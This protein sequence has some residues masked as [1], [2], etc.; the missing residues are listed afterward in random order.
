MKNAIF[1]SIDDAVRAI[2][3]L[4]KPE[5]ILFIET[6]A[7]QIATCFRS[8]G[9]ILIAGNGGSLCDAMHFAEELTGQ[10]RHKRMALPALALADPGHLSCVSN[11]MGY[12][13]VFARGVEAFGKKED[14]F[15]ALTTSGNSPNLMSA[16]QMAQHKGLYTIAFLG[17]TGGKMKGLCDLEWIVSGFPYSDRVQE[18]HMTAIHILIELVERKLFAQ[19]QTQTIALRTAVH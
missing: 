3:S 5:V 12:E 4:K 13:A 6:A 11:D 7:E 2:E 18:A 9:K 17:K 1:Q 16:V 15:I 14:V 19:N 10:F 8:G